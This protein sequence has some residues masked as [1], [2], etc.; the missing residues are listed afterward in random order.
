MKYLAE[1]WKASEKTNVV[2]LS[3]AVGESWEDGDGDHVKRA[4]GADGG[5]R[6]GWSTLVE[7]HEENLTN[8][9]PLTHRTPKA[10][11]DKNKKKWSMG[12]DTRDP[13]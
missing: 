5:E 3:T 6:L 12:V 13:W 1:E 11:H 8:S 2:R 9:S 4:E 10:F 7:R